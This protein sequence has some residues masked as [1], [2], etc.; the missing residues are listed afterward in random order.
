MS[1]SAREALPNVQECSGGPPECPRVV[2]SSFPNVQE[3][4][5]G[6]LGLPRGVGWP[7]R[8]SWSGQEALPDVRECSGGHPGCP[9]VLGRPSRLSLRGERPF[10]M[11]G[12]CREALLDIR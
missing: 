9:G 4:S 11:S 1:G 3:C 6:P 12:S 5:G 7:S 10:R 2:G 8:L